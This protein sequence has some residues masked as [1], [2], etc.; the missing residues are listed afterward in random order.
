[1]TGRAELVEEPSAV[2]RYTTMVRPWVEHEI[3][4][5]IR[6]KADVINGFRL[7]VAHTA[8]QSGR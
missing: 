5:V 2:E 8:E 6:I 4:Y 3:A 1:V 7:S